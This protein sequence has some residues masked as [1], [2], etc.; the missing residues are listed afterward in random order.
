MTF[1]NGKKSVAFSLERSKALVGKLALLI[2][3]DK[4]DPPDIPA[5][6]ANVE[7]LNTHVAGVE[8][9]GCLIV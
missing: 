4:Q 5:Q 9:I 7:P 3:S 2:Q 8:K 6:M 1:G